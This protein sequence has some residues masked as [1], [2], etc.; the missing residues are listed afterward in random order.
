MIIFLSE[1]HRIVSVKVAG[2]V[3]PGH[4]LYSPSNVHCNGVASKVSSSVDTDLVAKLACLNLQENDVFTFGQEDRDII[5]EKVNDT[6]YQ[7]CEQD[8]IHKHIDMSYDYDNYRL[9]A[10]CDDIKDSDN[11]W[12]MI[13]VAERE[14]L[15]GESHLAIS[16]QQVQ[17]S[18][19]SNSS[20]AL[21]NLP[22]T[23][24]SSTAS[25]QSCILQTKQPFGCA[26]NLTDP[27]IQIHGSSLPVT[28]AHDIAGD[29]SQNSRE[30]VYSEN[31]HGYS[32]QTQN[33]NGKSAFSS[34][35]CVPA[36]VAVAVSS[37]SHTQ[38][39]Q[40][41]LGRALDAGK[42]IA[43]TSSGIA[44]RK[45]KAFISISNTVVT[46]YL[47]QHL[48]DTQAKCASAIAVHAN[49]TEASLSHIWERLSKVLYLSEPTVGSIDTSIA[50]MLTC[51]IALYS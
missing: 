47:N 15:P 19:R 1:Y 3:Q 33:V 17:S 25:D 20:S 11:E 9:C 4:L 48:A 27:H 26:D 44:I 22:I 21:T 2:D 37:S 45:V 28:P 42:L 16:Y 36:G 6:P 14:I 18:S 49:S 24:C 13:D 12:I 38:I 35:V 41:L 32:H 43:T 8:L 30:K 51:F 31:M 23:R 40:I 39:D 29:C 46:R 5:K 7:W 10:G 34:D 50:I